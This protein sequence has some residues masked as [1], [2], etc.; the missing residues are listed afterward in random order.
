[1]RWC[2]CLVVEGRRKKKGWKISAVR[3]QVE[4]KVRSCK[5][6]HGLTNMPF[7]QS[8]LSNLPAFGCIDFYFYFI[9]APSLLL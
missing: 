5:V 2:G 1:M 4:N 6:E 7:F 9:S 3:V 8:I